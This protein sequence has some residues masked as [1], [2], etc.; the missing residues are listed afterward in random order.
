MNTFV[1][2][3]HL[4][5]AMSWIGGMIFLSLVV[6]PLFRR[7]GLSG[8]RLHLFR[9]IARRFRVLVWVAVG[10]LLTSG[11]VLIVQRGLPIGDVAAWPHPLQVKLTLVLCLVGLSLWHDL[12]LAARARSVS[13]SSTP[14][15][16]PVDWRAGMLARL[17]PRL[18]LL[19]ALAVVYAAVVLVRS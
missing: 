19:F 14:G 16:A 8:E 3:L 18:A 2:W 5:A 15:P 13:N 11:A 6:A 9:D 12:M 4:L 10:L 7:A 17:V 1:V